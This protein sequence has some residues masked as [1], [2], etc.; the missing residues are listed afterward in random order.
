MSE[1]SSSL[2]RH[3]NSGIEGLNSSL[4]VMEAEFELRS[5]WLQS[6]S[7]NYAVWQLT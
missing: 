5:V 7:S 6:P 1:A 4:K 2:Y 3:I